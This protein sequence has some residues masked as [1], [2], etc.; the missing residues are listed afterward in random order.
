MPKSIIIIHC[1]SL[2]Y[3]II[4]YHHCSSSIIIIAPHPNGH[5]QILDSFLEKSSF[6]SARVTMLN[7]CV[8]VTA[9]PEE[10][11]GVPSELRWASKG[12]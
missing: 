5:K 7:R 2:S 12:T 10:R 9:L 6:G 4:H 1:H 3:I 8:P 11:F